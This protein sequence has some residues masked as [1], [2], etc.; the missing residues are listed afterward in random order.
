MRVIVSVACVFILCFLLRWEEHSPSLI[1]PLFLYTIKWLIYR[2]MKRG[3]KKIYVRLITK[4][5]T[6]LHT[7]L[8]YY[9]QIGL[10]VYTLHILTWKIPFEKMTLS[11]GQ[12]AIY[13]FPYQVV[14]HIIYSGCSSEE[15]GPF[16]TRKKNIWHI[17]AFRYGL[18][19]MKLVWFFFLNRYF[20]S[21]SPQPPA[22]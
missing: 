5:S 3:T 18:C 22:T 12:K 17:S 11:C 13:Y 16:E 8:F 10:E 2:P 1:M 4:L 14:F 7:Y 19:L 20:R 21:C 6:I 15:T 9:L